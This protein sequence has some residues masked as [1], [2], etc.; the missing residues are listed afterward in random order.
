MTS[1][2]ATRVI[3]A[4][5]VFAFGILGVLPLM[6]GAQPQRDTD[7]TNNPNSSSQTAKPV[8]PDEST[9]KTQ[10]EQDQ[11]V[12]QTIEALDKVLLIHEAM[13]KENPQFTAAS[14]LLF[15]LNAIPAESRYKTLKQWI[16]PTKDRNSVRHFVGLLSDPPPPNVFL[17]AALK[18]TLPPVDDPR[19]STAAMLVDAARDAGKLNE[20]A[21]DLRPL[22]ERQIEG[23][24]ILESLVLV[25]KEGASGVRPRVSSAQLEQLID[26]Q[27]NNPNQLG[28]FSGV[29]SRYRSQALAAIDRTK[30]ATLR[31]SPD[32]GLKHWMPVD[33]NTAASSNTFNSSSWWIALDD[34]I[35]HVCA[36][37]VDHLVF[38]YPLTGI[39][40]IDCES[41]NAYWSEGNVGFGGL[42]PEVWNQGSPIKSILPIN[43]HE[44]FPLPQ[45]VEFLNQFNPVTFKVRLDNL[46]FI[47]NKKLL[48]EDFS[49]STTSPFL[50]LR[51]TWLSAFRKLRITG[52]VLIPNE[53]SLLAGN[54]M[55]GWMTT[56]YNESQPAEMTARRQHPSSPVV[57]FD[58]NAYDWSTAKSE[59]RGRRVALLDGT[60]RPTGFL[61][62]ESWVYFHRPIRN[63]EKVRYEFFYQ[64]GLEAIEVHPTVDR[65]AFLLHPDGVK[66]HWLTTNRTQEKVD[67]WIPTDNVADEPA[68]RRGPKRLPLN[69]AAWNEACI[70]IRE[71]MIRLELNG[72]L[73]YERPL[74]TESGSR[75]GL[76][77]DVHKTSSRIR[78]IVL[79]GD[80]PEWSPE[81]ASNL[82]ERKVPLAPADERA[83]R[84]IL[85]PRLTAK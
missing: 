62:G 78:N 3:K 59:L 67:G 5:I 68:N 73:V 66:L 38:A 74:E 40:E 46:Q 84:A 44:R 30:G 12:R 36:P 70:E 45:P 6:L 8:R 60:P 35:G 42:M 31:P 72:E 2:Q 71:G 10:A 9:G 81:L 4:E 56:F 83:I 15:R 25:A 13:R 34:R 64:Q 23:A 47:A 11:Q 80:W 24:Q 28:M 41:F 69:D 18:E 22:A 76:Y 77:H 48:Y 57:D 54:R 65:L 26:S 79:S 33:L 75:F 61:H 49:P 50:F 29:L 14:R 19:I 63:S 37:Y 39:F 53:V 51:T 7:S 1:F 85:E 20:L 32:P 16:F 58:P 27:L 43:Y 17:N 82:L 21:A 55:D 52:Q